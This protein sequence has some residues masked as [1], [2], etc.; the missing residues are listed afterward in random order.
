[1]KKRVIALLAILVF[2]LILVGK[3]KDL[4]LMYWRDYSINGAYEGDL[5]RKKIL[6]NIP[7]LY[8]Y[9]EYIEQESDGEACLFI[10]IF[11]KIEV[12]VTDSIKAIDCYPVYVGE[13]WDTHNVNWDWFYINEKM[14]KMYWY[15]VIEGGIYSL[16]E[17]RNG[18]RYR[19]L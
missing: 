17:W 3:E 13:K 14:D 1:M 11:E 16:E 18:E 7:E 4:P 15:D 9:A 19:D 6:E 12:D 10:Q 2:V 8:D 5:I